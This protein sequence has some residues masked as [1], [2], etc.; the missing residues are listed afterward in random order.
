MSTESEYKMATIKGSLYVMGKG[1]IPVMF[2]LVANQSNCVL[3]TDGMVSEVGEMFTD[4]AKVS[5]NALAHMFVIES[6]TGP[7]IC[8]VA[9]DCYVPSLLIE[10]TV[11]AVNIAKIAERVIDENVPF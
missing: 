1:G 6:V 10:Q 8:I 2:P 3:V 5:K 7:C 9:I 11:V 4:C